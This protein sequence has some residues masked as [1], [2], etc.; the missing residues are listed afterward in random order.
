MERMRTT[1]SFPPLLIQTVYRAGCA[2][3][4]SSVRAV[5]LQTLRLSFPPFFSLSSLAELKE[6]FLLFPLFSFSSTGERGQGLPMI[7]VMYYRLSWLAFL[8]SLFFF[9]SFFFPGSRPCFPL[10]FPPQVIAHARTIIRTIM[11]RHRRAAVLFPFF[12]FLEMKNFR[13]RRVLT[14][15]LLRS[16]AVFFY[17]SSSRRHLQI[18]KSD[19]FPFSLSYAMEPAAPCLYPQGARRD[20]FSFFRPRSR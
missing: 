19:S 6:R 2:R 8:P 9:M 10:P 15:F 14:V 7:I 16:N 20:L 5:L 12:F 17:P 4:L 1:F 11:L 3:P 13:A 18:A